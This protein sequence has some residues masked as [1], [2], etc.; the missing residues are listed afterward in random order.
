L[1]LYYTLWYVTA[2]K[3][4][5]ALEIFVFLFTDVRHVNICMELE[6]KHAY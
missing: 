5:L 1:L 4:H 6:H 3:S 2:D